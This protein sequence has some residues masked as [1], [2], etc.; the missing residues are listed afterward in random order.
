MLSH[1]PRDL[2]SVVIAYLLSESERKYMA[3]AQHTIVLMMPQG[4]FPSISKN[5]AGRMLSKFGIHWNS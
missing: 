1:A 2:G 5:T 4:F 3:A